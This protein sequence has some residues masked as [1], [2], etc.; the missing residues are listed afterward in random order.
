LLGD[1]VMRTAIPIPVVFAAACVLA[2]TAS[3]DSTPMSQLSGRVIDTRHKTPVESAL[4]LVAGGSGVEHTLTTDAKGAFA[5]TVTPGSYYLIFVYG[6]ARSST[7]V[8]LEPHAQVQVIGQVD[9]TEGEVI[10]I[11]DKIQPPV[12]PKPTNHKP[13][14]APPYSDRAVVHD[15]WTKAHML[16][17][18]DETGKL[19]R[20]KWLK[21]PGYDLDKIAISEVTRL[22]FQPARDT[23]GK[24]MRAWL[25]WSI[26]WPSAWWLD[27]FI[28][29]RTSMPRVIH[30]DKRQDDY[31]PCKGS[32]KPWHMG[33]MHKTYKDC[34]KPDLR[35]AATEPWFTP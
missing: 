19:L 3:A 22:K 7:R 9:A 23:S 18:I 1:H 2:A 33:S 29:T 21:R 14:K 26:E 27:K 15:A 12:P 35:V 17:D 11:Q 28:G 6:T 31:V 5:A 10:I 34:S 13:R 16:L 20:I 30:G 4:V 25:V 32:G 24:P 8:T